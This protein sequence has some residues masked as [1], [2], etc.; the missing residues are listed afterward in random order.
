VGP[1]FPS[2]RRCAAVVALAVFALV[3]LAGALTHHER[4]L[5]VPK[6]EAIRR[7]EAIPLIRKVVRPGDRA[8][9][10]YVDD[11]LVKVMWYR[12][13]DAIATAGVDRRL[14]VINQGA[15]K[16]QAGWGAD[17]SHKAIALALCALLFALVTLR[18]PLRLDR[19]LLDVAMV[20][21]LV[22]PTVL[23]DHGRFAHGEGLV[24]LLLL[25]L[26][27]RGVTVA[28]RGPG[29]ADRPD[30]PVLLEALAGRLRAP[31]L[32]AQLGGALLVATVMVIVTST[33]L[34]DIAIADMEGATVL[35]HG[36]LPYGHMPGDI[37]HGDTYGLPIYAFYAPFAALWPM[38]D[39]WDN[40]LGALV[41]NALLLLVCAAGIARATGDGDRRWP[42]ILGF[43]AFP[44]ALMATSS[45]TNDIMIAAL[46][47]WAFAW[48]RRPAASS[49]LVMLAGTAKLAPLV[50]M[51]LW[52]ARLRGAELVRATLA[53]AA[54]GAAVVAGLI[55]VGGL[56]GPADM[57]D[58]IGFQFART[59]ELSVWTQLGLA[60]L[61]PLAQGLTMAAALGGAVL[62]LL[63]RDV[64]GDPRR[65]AGLV[66]AVLAGL[67]LSANHWAPLYLLWLAPPV[68]V[69]LL[70]PLGARAAVRAHDEQDVPAGARLAPAGT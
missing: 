65:V 42:A 61:Q 57:A 53:C 22:V 32:P 9:V 55:V 23:I 5:G 58:A 60:A 35:L 26:I 11:H 46:L 14:G 40:S 15:I 62:V 1:S 18:A 48:W 54:V 66:T 25:Y 47:V 28:V 63:D 31:R 69:S 43:L 30:A 50:L 17:L 12:G 56:H 68:M 3:A 19:R 49:A 36:H 70:G 39:G 27:A 13:S 24:A 16:D 52:L 51:P 37:V 7:A 44:A 2:A 38:R 20:T 10:I 8:R 4:P 6:D 67:Q 41:S 33:G 34:V 59:S 29:A 64:A 45:G 21:A